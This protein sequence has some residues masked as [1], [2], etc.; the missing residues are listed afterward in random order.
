MPSNARP[1]T[2]KPRGIC[3]YYITPRGCFAGS[4]CK[5]LHGAAEQLD[6]QEPLLTPYDA[7][8]RCKFYCIRQWRDQKGQQIERG[9]MK[10]CPMCREPS[11]FIT[12][13][14]RFWKHG[15]PEKDRVTK[16]YRDSMAKVPCRYF[17]QCLERN[18]PRP[19][20]P[21][22]KD[23]FYQHLKDD[24]TPY[25]FRHGADVCM[26]VQRSHNSAGAGRS[27]RNNR[28]REDPLIRRQ[29]DILREAMDNLESAVS[30]SN[31]PVA[32][33]LDMV[34]MLVQRHTDFDG[35][36]NSVSESSLSEAYLSDSDD[37]DSDS[38]EISRLGRYLRSAASRRFGESSDSSEVQRD[39]DEEARLMQ[40]IAE[41]DR[42][43][44]TNPPFLTDGRGRVVWSSDGEVA[45]PANSGLR[46]S[47]ETLDGDEL[48]DEMHTKNN[49]LSGA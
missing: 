40:E 39:E 2:S 46:Q 1:R 17:K 28:L 8:K 11:R 32:R 35:M 20:C 22:G 23:C 44:V 45:E 16:A 25:V 36:P 10:K 12:P 33:T 14:S 6:P 38:D 9:N 13:S 15:H 4:S 21:F 30:T 48:V 26:P 5:F 24:G 31:D 19:L 29:L 47:A 34:R 18:N 27:R 41:R 7:A 49:G 37:G 43:R 42:G 3:K